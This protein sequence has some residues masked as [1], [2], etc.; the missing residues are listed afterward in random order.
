MADIRVLLELNW[1]GDSPTI[2]IRDDEAKTSTHIPLIGLGLNYR[3][4]AESKAHCLGHRAFGA[5]GAVY[6]DCSRGPKPKAKKCVRCSISDAAF[7]SNIHH[8]HKKDR[9]GIDRFYAAHL[10]KTN[11]LYLAGFRDGSIKIG[12]S[13]A[14]RRETRLLEQGAWIAHIV[15]KAADGY[16]VREIEDHV[17]EFLHVSQSVSA[18]R[19]LSGHLEPT[20]DQDLEVRL[21]ALAAKV[22]AL[23]E[24]L[25]DERLTSLEQEW[26]NPAR[27]TPARAVVAYPLDPR[28][29][30]HNLKI[31]EACGRIVFCERTGADGTPDPEVFVFDVGLLFG[32]ELQLGLFAS[33]EASVQASLF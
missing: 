3:V 6:I 4:A 25:N 29:G 9:S 13:T 10:A 33:D 5:E 32:L 14:L 26:S 28:M 22:R 19:K 27:S 23:A 8:A 21:G 16:V 2:R 31:V 30:S 15:A 1:S 24:A 7:A 17:T 11:F 12:T 20:A 18:S